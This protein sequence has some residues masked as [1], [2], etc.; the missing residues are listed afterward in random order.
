MILTSLVSVSSVPVSCKIRVLD[1]L[2]DTLALVR[3]IEKCGVAAVGVHGRRRDERQGDANR[4][5]EIR[6]VVRA[7]SIPVIA[8]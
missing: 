4:V 8:K 1:K 3:L 7:L 2:E 6:E 5:N